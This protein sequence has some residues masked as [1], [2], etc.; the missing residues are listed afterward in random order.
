MA[1][2]S[3]SVGT[4]ADNDAADVEV[5]QRCLV[6]HKAFAGLVN[7]ECGTDTIAAIKAFQKSFMPH[8]D[9]R[10][11]PGGT[12][13]KKL[14]GTTHKKFKIVHGGNFKAT[15][16]GKHLNPMLLQKVTALCQHLIDSDLVTAN[17]VFTQGV[18]H[19]KTAHK[20]STSWNIR[21]GRV[22]L[23]D[24]QDLA[25][26][27]D[28]D[29]NRWY[30]TAWEEGLAKD[31]KGHL[32]KEGLTK[33]WTKIKA[34]ALTY[35][36][37]NAI[38]AEGYATT[39]DH[40]KPNVHPVVSNHV[41]GNA[42]DVSIPWKAGAQVGDQAVIDGKTSDTVANSLVTQFGLSR[43]IATE[44]WHFQ[45]A[46]TAQQNVSSANITGETP[47]DVNPHP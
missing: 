28:R 14:N 23:K 40:I 12:T 36:D 26:G 4:D 21:K 32:P 39:D 37:S 43:P 18:R 10:V 5:V 46:Q 45:L 35:Y 19:P 29:G 44:K 27:K 31:A 22:P 38:A 1:C 15:D 20:W 6:N 34:N 11:D 16:D 7:G 42:M 30:D 47:G 3:G 13:L 9:G 25:G 33:L 17:I 8:P 2:L 24:L 41:G